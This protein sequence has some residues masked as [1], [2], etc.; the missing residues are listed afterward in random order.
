[1]PKKIKASIVIATRNEEKT[2]EACIESLLNQS[3]PKNNYEIIFADGFSSDRTPEIIQSYSKKSKI[4]IIILENLKKDS[5]SGR[6]LGIKKSRGEFIVQLSGHTVADKNLLKILVGKLEKSPKD[7]AAVGCTHKTPGTASFLQK[8]FGA[9]M[10]SYVGGF[11]TSQIQPAREEFV[12]SLSFCAFRKK[13]LLEV[14]LNDPKFKVGQ[15]AELNIRIRKAGYK[16]LYTPKTFVWYYKRPNYPRFFM[17]MFRYGWGRARMMQKH[18]DTAKII[19]FAPASF[20]ILFA[21]LLFASFRSLTAQFLFSL[22]FLSY[23]AAVLFSSAKSA[24]SFTFL[25]AEYFAFWAMH[26]G[27]GI[28]FLWGVFSKIKI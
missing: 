28:G 15:D 27:Y 5:G 10:G 11:G 8:V 21:G 23:S 14:G 17:Q 6:N 18:P 20:T 2:I 7:V 13:V 22:L 4:P 12:E 26:L 19:Y 1:M 25:L 24:N 9:A 16:F 3:Y